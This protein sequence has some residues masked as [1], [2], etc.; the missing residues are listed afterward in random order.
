[1]CVCVFVCV[2]VCVCMQWVGESLAGA[3]AR[4]VHH[5]GGWGTAL[6]PPGMQEGE[7]DQGLVD[8]IRQHQKR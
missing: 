2:C 1:M 5:Q 3:L 4:S 6:A 8:A 7:M